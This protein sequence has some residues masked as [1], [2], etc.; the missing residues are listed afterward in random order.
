MNNISQFEKYGISFLETLNKTQISKMVKECDKQYYY[1]NNSNSL[2]SDECYD[3]LINYAEQNNYIECEK[4]G[5][6]ADVKENKVKL[7][8]LMASMYKMKVEKSS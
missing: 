7:P 4:C 6:M 5:S 1:S 2:L 3:I 8:Y